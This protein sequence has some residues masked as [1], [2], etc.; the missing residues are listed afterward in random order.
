MTRRSGF[1]GF[2]PVVA[3]WVAVEQA[4]TARQERLEQ[5]YEQAHAAAERARAAAQRSAAAA[6]E[7]RRVQPTPA[8][9]PAAPAAPQPPAVATRVVPEAEY[10]LLLR[11]ADA[12]LKHI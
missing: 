12:Y 11:A 5:R 1:V 7:G 8:L 10:K 6:A 9:A 3:D 4:S 2:I